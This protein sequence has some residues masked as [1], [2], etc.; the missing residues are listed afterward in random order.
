MTA[1]AGAT[2]TARADEAPAPPRVPGTPDGRKVFLRHCAPCHGERGDGMGRAAPWLA[3]RPRDFTAGVYRFRT[4]NSG[5]PPTDDDLVRTIKRGIPGTPMPSWDRILSDDEIR[6]VIKV[7]RSL[8]P[9]ELAA[10]PPPSEVLAVP[11]APAE[12]A[13][14]AARGRNVFLLMGCFNCHGVRGAGDG[15]AVLQDDKGNPIRALD[16]TKGYLK[17]GGRPEDVYR[18]LLTGL[19]GSP[20][21]SFKDALVLVK[22]SYQDLSGVAPV[23][24]AGEL[25]EVEA[26]VATLPTQAAFD[27]LSDADREKLQAS[28]RWDLV[29]YV[30]SLG[31]RNAVAKWLFDAPYT[32]K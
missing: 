1:A 11:K 17:G 20:M 22:D 13:M 19:D 3:V 4:T 6:A 2:G 30:R 10:A 27:A 29:A 18:T 9:A 21:P 23:V 24:S 5:T 14:S 7:L 12:A 8:A 32:T 31:Q 15:K 25:K 26:Y 28:W 16:F